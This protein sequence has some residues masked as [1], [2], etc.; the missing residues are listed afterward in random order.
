[1]ILKGLIRFSVLALILIG[2]GISGCSENS[3]RI[4]TPQ[5]DASTDQLSTGLDTG[6]VDGNPGD[7]DG[8]PIFDD[9][10]DDDQSGFN[11][12]IDKYVQ[13]TDGGDG[14]FTKPQDF[15]HR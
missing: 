3:D 13:G 15:L 10:S 12:W 11:D 5:A 7:N 9:S 8:Y 14:G 6:Y 2:I 1:M 4:F